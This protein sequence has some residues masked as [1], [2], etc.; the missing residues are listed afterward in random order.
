MKS[1]RLA[2]KEWKISYEKGEE[3]WE[4]K[5]MRYKDMVKHEDWMEQQDIKVKAGKKK[6]LGRR[7]WKWTYWNM[8]KTAHRTALELSFYVRK[9]GF[10]ECGTRQYI[11]MRIPNF[12]HRT[13]MASRVIRMKTNVTISYWQIR[14]KKSYNM[15]EINT[16]QTVMLLQSPQHPLTIRMYCDM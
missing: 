12:P 6:K 2:R 11:R 5:K 15:K 13:P 8:Q 14:Y 1:D 3:I 4:D 16:W 10:Q 7:R 9:A